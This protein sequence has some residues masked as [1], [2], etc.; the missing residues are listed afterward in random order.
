GPFVVWLTGTIQTSATYTGVVGH[1]YGFYSVATDNVGNREATPSAAQATTTATNS[2]TITWVNAAGGDWD[3]PANWDLNRLPTATDD[4]VINTT[5]ITITHAVARDD[6]VRSL[7]TRA[8]I[9]LSAGSLSI[10][11]TSSINA[12][13]TINGG[14]LLLLN[15]PL[16]GSGALVNQG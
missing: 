10:V 12:T 13:F 15:A 2:T 6:A 16:N 7:T 14:T 5:G 11:G 4:V 8:A 3:T 1:T 9:N